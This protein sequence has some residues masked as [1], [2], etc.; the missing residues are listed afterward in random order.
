MPGKPSAIPL[1]ER[2]WA[3]VDRSGGPDACWPWQGARIR[4]YG[5]FKACDHTVRAHRF[6]WELAFGS[7]SGDLHVLH[8]CPGGDDRAC[9]NPKHLWLGTNADNVADRVAKGRNGA[10]LGESN[11]KAKLRRAQVIE[12]RRRLSLGEAQLP[13]A[14]D[15]GVRQTAVSKIACGTYWRWL[16]TDE[17]AP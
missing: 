15:F 8:N 12:I 1:E 9:V 14:C 10:A 6:S 11:G 3:H 4:G 5:H 13:I 16:V 2:F 7:I 17:V